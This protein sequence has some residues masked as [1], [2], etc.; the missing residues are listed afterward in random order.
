MVEKYLLVWDNVWLCG[1]LFMI[2]WWVNYDL[3]LLLNGVMMVS[4]VIKEIF[5][6]EWL[7][8]LEFI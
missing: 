2:V 3:R 1:D 6:V 5:G 4:E 7:E 8:D